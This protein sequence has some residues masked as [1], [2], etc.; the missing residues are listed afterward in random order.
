MLELYPSF[1]IIE[2]KTIVNDKYIVGY[3]NVEVSDEVYEQLMN[4]QEKVEL[5]K[6]ILK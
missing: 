1:A 5:I 4:N 2:C 3:G 6:T